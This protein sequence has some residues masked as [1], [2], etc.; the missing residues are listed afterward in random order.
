[1][2][3][4]YQGHTNTREPAPPPITQFVMYLQLPEIICVEEMSLLLG[5]IYVLISSPFKSCICF[6]TDNWNSYAA[7]VYLLTRTT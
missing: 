4:V 1:M 2:F 6:D 7:F 5:F 3:M